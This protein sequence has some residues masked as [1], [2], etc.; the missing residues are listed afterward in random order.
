MIQIRPTYYFSKKKK[1]RETL[2]IIPHLTFIIV[3][4][5]CPNNEN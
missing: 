5:N 2:N 1:Q 4:K 3:P